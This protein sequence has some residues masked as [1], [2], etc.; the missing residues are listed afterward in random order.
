M[1]NLEIKIHLS[2]IETAVKKLIESIA[3]DTDILVGEES[4]LWEI[5]E[6]LSSEDFASLKKNVYFSDLLRL[7]SISMLLSKD[8]YIKTAES[9]SATSDAGESF[10]L[11]AENSS[12]EIVSEYQ[13]AFRSNRNQIPS[14]TTNLDDLHLP[15]RFTKLVKVLRGISRA[16]EA[17]KLGE[18]F[19]DLVSLSVSEVASLPRVGKL[20]VETF[21]ELKRLAKEDMV[22]AVEIEHEEEIKFTA[23]DISNMRLSHAGVDAAFTKALEK[24]ARYIGSNDLA[25]YLHEILKFDRNTLIELPGFGDGV[26]D[27]LVEFRRVVQKEIKAIVAG[28]VDYEDLQSSLVVPKVF[29]QLSVEKIEKVLLEDID[30]FLERMPDD[31]A[32]IAQKRWGF[33]EGKQTLEEIAEGLSVTRER[34]RQ[35]ETKINSGFLQCLRINQRSLWKF[36]EPELSIH[37]E[38]KVGNLFSCFS[39]KKDF[40]DFLGLVCGQEKLFEYVYPDLDK[41]ILNTFFVENGA[42]II[43]NDVKEYFVELGLDGVRNIDNAIQ[44]LAQQGV[45]LI[46]G[47]FVWPR[48]LGKAEASACVL[49]NHERGLPWMDIAKLVNRNGY[50][51]T[52][53]SEERLDNEAFKLPEY[54]FLAGKGVYKHTRFIDAESISLDDIFIEVMEY[55]ESDQRSVFHLM[56]CYLASNQ[57]QKHD[58]FVIRYF[59]K[60]FGEDYGFY[61]DGRSQSDSLGLE[62]GFKNITQKDVIVEAMNRIGKPLT[63]PEV[64]NLLKSKSRNHASFY[65]DSL[66]HEGKIVQVDRMLYTTPDLAYR[67]IQ[68]DQFVDAIDKILRQYA[69]PVEPSIFKEELNRFFSKSYSK[70]FYASIARLYAERQGWF[71]MHST[72]SINNIPFKNINTLLNDVCVP[73]ASTDEN[74]ILLQEHIAITRE[75]AAVAFSNWGGAQKA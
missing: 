73:N 28:A 31:D 69:K 20:Y 5:C 72:Y 42:P 63:K 44:Y 67:S 55:A 8:P 18:T 6:Q 54:I 30:D 41:S 40:Y 27:K 22:S 45:L 36:L 50:S 64:A 29:S 51:R 52:D 48:Q 58:Y 10:V 16:H 21:K 26:V 4:D 39:S 7:L 11:E 70:Y 25:D 75:A 46:E 47:E 38:T 65:I 49:V 17:F 34:I 61:F 53:I 37:I 23:V 19:G 15:D 32:D 35:K 13:F 71:R 56:E 62:K 59:V 74:I 33:V 9:G 1:E 43:L 2:Q 14:P 66:M 12:K 24:Y 57:L 3:E 68:I 60:Q